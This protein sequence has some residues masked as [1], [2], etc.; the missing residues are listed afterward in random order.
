MTA[1]STPAS[2]LYLIERRLL[3]ARQADV[4]G[5]IQKKSRAADV[6][7]MRHAWKSGQEIFA[8]N[9]WA[10]PRSAH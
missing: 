1:N 4:R 2:Q 7:Q 3:I 6:L 5:V 10:C 9:K 8:L